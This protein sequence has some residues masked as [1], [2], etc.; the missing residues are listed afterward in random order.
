MIQRI[1]LTLIFLRFIKSA[2][3]RANFDGGRLI[4]SATD[5][6]QSCIFWSEMTTD[7]IGA[8]PDK[9]N[10]AISNSTYEY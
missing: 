5:E 10:V 9:N 2:G 3:F 6:V 4:H 1:I 7:P 8:F